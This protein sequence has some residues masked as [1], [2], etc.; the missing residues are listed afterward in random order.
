MYEPGHRG[1]KTERNHMELNVERPV[2][3]YESVVI[4]HP[5]TSE[6]GQR[7]LFRKNKEII[8][9]FLGEINHIDTWGKRRLGNPIDKVKMGIYFHCTFT[10]KAECIQE[11]ERTMRI[12]DQVLRFFHQRLD[13]RKSVGEHLEKYREVIETSRIRDQEREAKAQAR[14]NQ[15]KGSKPFR[16]DRGSFHQKG[17]GDNPRRDSDDR[18]RRDSDDRPRRTSD[19][20]PRR[21]SDDKPRRDSDDKPR[22]DSDDRPSRTSDDKPRRTSD[23]RPRRDFDDK[24]TVDKGLVQ[25]AKTRDHLPGSPDKTG[26]DQSDKAVSDSKDND[27]GGQSGQAMSDKSD[28]TD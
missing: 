11:L 2:R 24:P 19:D 17:A 5:D 8:Q 3:N 25:K 28:K 16:R 1:L 22:R 26:G 27:A 23:D 13:T 18:P 9:K 12:S 20:K 10:A 21:D 4:M 15:A 6:D 14:K 7:N